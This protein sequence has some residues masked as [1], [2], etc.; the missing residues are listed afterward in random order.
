MWACLAAMS[1][2]N[3]ELNTA[4]VALAAIEVVD[5]LQFIAHIK[6]IPSIEGRNAELF[7]FKGMIKEAESLLLQAG[8]V[9]RAI[10]LNIR[11][12]NWER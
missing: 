7:L 12:Y 3:N 2:D 10:K 8:L 6:E 4:E 9:W 11:L 5:K 1:I